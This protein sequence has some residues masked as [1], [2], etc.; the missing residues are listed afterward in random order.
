MKLV[1]HTLFSIA[2]PAV[3]SLAAPV[4]ERNGHIITPATP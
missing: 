2:I 3:S 1:I 4:L